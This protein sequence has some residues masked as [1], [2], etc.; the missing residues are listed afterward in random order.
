MSLNPITNPCSVSAQAYLEE[1]EAHRRKLLRVLG[2]SHRRG[3]LTVIR[4][5]SLL[6]QDPRS[7]MG[8]L[9][10]AVMT[11]PVEHCECNEVGV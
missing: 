11:Q 8:K 1:E 4:A 10:A 5:V 3:G 2:P 9:L 7:E 6:A